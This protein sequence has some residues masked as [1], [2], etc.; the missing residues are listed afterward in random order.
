VLE[1][2][3]E[4]PVPLRFACDD[5]SRIGADRIANAIG[6]HALHGGPI[7]VIDF[8]TAT[9][10]DLVSEDGAFL[11]GAIAPE[12]HL[13]ARAL[14]DR[15][16]QLHAVA[17]DVPKSVIGK[18]TAENLRAGIVLGFLDLIDGLISRFRAEYRA[19][20]RVAAT[21]GRGKLFYEHLD[22]IERYEPFLTLTGL[23]RWWQATAE[24]D[25]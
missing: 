13:T 18:T 8:G 16:A 23:Q 7:L 3:A 15:A 1:L 12:M 4:L 14:T 9:T 5:P 10:F 2:R 19:D 21:G 17:L 24:R 20:L 25:A 11:G 22:A 6:G